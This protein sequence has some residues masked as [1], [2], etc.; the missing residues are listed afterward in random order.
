MEKRVKQS[1][2]CRNITSYNINTLLPEFRTPKM[3]DVGI[4]RVI[5]PKGNA[6]VDVHGSTYT[7]FE[8]DL[9]MLSFGNRYATNQYEGYVP[10]EPTTECELLAR[11]GVAGLVHSINP[12]FRS[13]PAKLELIGYATDHD[14]VVLNTIET[15]LSRFNPNS[16]RPKVVLSIGTSMDS[17]KTTTA[18]YLCGG[19]KKAGHS[20]AF[21]KLTGTAYPKDAQLNVDRGADYGTDFSAF[22]YPST[23]M[24]SHSELLNLYQSLVE[25]VVA[26]VN[27]EYIVMEIADGLL[28]RETNALL[29]DKNFMSTIHNTIFSSGDSLSVLTGLQ[30]LHDWGCAPFAVAGL[31]TSSELLI[32]EVQPFIDTPILRLNEVLDGKAVDIL[33]GV[34][35]NVSYGMEM[36]YSNNRV[37]L[38]A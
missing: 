30:M 33:R 27:P 38:R 5:A 26:E 21:I 23:Y 2:A 20:V 31:F 18:A 24:V 22:G 4:F 16:K 25:K 12:T 6:L 19:L 37:A 11:G 32:R 15:K 28:Q 35:E 3:G 9:I 13:T 34:E 36:S 29:K 8:E 7:L 10:S 1:F 14:G 17:G